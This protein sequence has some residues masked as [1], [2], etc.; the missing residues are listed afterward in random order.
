MRVKNQQDSFVILKKKN[1]TEKT[2][3]K[4][5]IHNGSIITDQKAI[6]ET[7]RSFYQHLFDKKEIL[8]DY[9]LEN[10]LRTIL[11]GVKQN[12]LENVSIGQKLTTFEVT[13]ALKQMKNN[14]TPGIDG[15][16]ADFL[17]IFWGKLKFFVTR[18]LNNCFSKGKMSYSLRQ[19]III[20]L[21][22]GEK[23]RQLLKNW[24]PISLLCVTYK[25]ASTVISNRMRPYLE[26]L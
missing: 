10:E 9:T 4:L 2:I 15:I 21:P 6:L 19:S 20:C 12:K 26:K 24:R 8:E 11:K 16:S 23:D 5:K 22:K 14:K 7:V 13:Q 18:A 25:L 1:F 17:K 3:R